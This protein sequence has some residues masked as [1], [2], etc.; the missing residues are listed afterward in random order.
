[1][2]TASEKYLV[3][4]AAQHEAFDRGWDMA[5]AAR[6]HDEFSVIR[7]PYNPE[8]VVAYDG[9]PIAPV[10]TAYARTF[11]AAL[12]AAADAAERGDGTQSQEQHG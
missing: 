4:V 5:E 9:V 8:L 2:S 3:D 12:L 7:Q 10:S 11:A 1:M 6:E